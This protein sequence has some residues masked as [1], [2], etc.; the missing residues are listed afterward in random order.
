MIKIQAFGGYSKIGKSMTA[1]D[2][3]GEIILTDMGADIEK[4]VDFEDDKS[5]ISVH[6]TPA[7][8]DNG[9]IPNDVKFFEENGKKVKAIVLT[10]GHLDHVWGVPFLAAKYKCPVIATPFTIKVLDNLMKNF[11]QKGINT[12]RLNTGTEY[13]LS[14]SISVELVNI[15]HS[16]PNSAMTVIH[17]KY[18]AI[19]YANDWKLDDTPTL[20]QKPNYARM[21][22][23]G[24]K[25]V[26]TLILDSTNVDHDGYTFS[27]SVVRTMLEDVIKKSLSNKTIFITTFS[28]HI[29]RIKNIV[30][31]S[32]KSDRQVLIFGRSM[33]MYIGA[34]IEANIIEKS[35]LPEV[36]TGR[37][38]IN[39]ILRYVRGKPGKYVILCTG[40]QGEKGAFLDKLAT[41]QYEYRLGS[42]D[43]VIFSSR[44]IPTTLNI[45]NRSILQTALE[46]LN[47]NIA[48]NVHVSGHGSKNDYKLMI[49]ML[50]PKHLIPSHGGMDKISVAID[51]ARDL[52]YELN[53]TSHILL[54]GQELSLE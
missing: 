5:I 2:V 9:V 41:G 15:T 17:T 27:E 10:H 7:L 42:D 39:D 25:G 11:R 49:K 14:E 53:K 6:D 36:I 50:R 51:V 13:K 48:D 52:G 44:V 43:A 19:V 24:D 29:A 28:S 21:Q 54:D 22:E 8:I 47:V 35:K 16:I 34:A 3:D 20:G 38:K 18:G 1:I 4:L 12:V 23:L 37:T 32:R 31:I 45:A 46:K 33:A 30:E 26:H 40:H